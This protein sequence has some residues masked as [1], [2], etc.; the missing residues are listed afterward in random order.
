MNKNNY[1]I[2]AY[3]IRVSNSI[4]NIIAKDGYNLL[5]PDGSQTEKFMPNA[6]CLTEKE[7][8]EKYA[9]FVDGFWYWKTK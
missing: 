2:G 4:K 8:K 7:Y 1:W 5:Y 3:D 6:P 9:K